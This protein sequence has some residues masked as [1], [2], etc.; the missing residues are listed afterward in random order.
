MADTNTSPVCNLKIPPLVSRLAPSPT[1][2]LH[3]GNARTFLW[4]WLSARSQ[5]GR[6]IMR[7]EDLETRGKPGVTEKIL[8]DLA[9]LGLDWDE[10]PRRPSFVQGGADMSEA[11]AGE[12]RALETESN[13]PKDG[14]R[15][16]QSHRRPF[17][18][19]IHAALAA[20]GA[21]Y[22]CVCTRADIAASQSAPHEGD[23]EPR[24]PNTCRGRSRGG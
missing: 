18:E 3:L 23:V 20:S 22:P 7:I 5:G 8:D 6:M 24:Y 9:W 11:S 15:Y 2:V 16:I 21:I 4:A 1:G 13:F 19:R 14:D 10:G 12:V 17:Y